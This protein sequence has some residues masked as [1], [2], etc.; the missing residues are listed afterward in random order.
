MIMHNEFDDIN[1]KTDPQ[2]WLD[3][4]DGKLSDQE[5]KQMEEE[6]AQSEFLRDALDGLTPADA[7]Q[8]LQ[9]VVKELNSNLERSLHAK[10]KQ[11]KRRPLGDQLWIWVTIALLLGICLLGYFFFVHFSIHGQ[12]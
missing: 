3:F 1:P 2:R 11:R 9:S 4:L 7:R 8:D 6:I 5:R 12:G 10:K